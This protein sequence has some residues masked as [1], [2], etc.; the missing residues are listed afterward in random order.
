MPTR[1]RLCESMRLCHGNLLAQRLCEIK[2]HGIGR[3]LLKNFIKLAE[4]FGII[5]FVFQ[6]LAQI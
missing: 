3:I 6:R 5:S 1:F 4:G 2:C